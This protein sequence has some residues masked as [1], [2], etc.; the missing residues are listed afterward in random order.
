MRAGLSLG[1]GFTGCRAAVSLTM[2]LCDV[3]GFNVP[4]GTD[5]ER[6]EWIAHEFDVVTGTSESER[7]FDFWPVELG[8]EK[9]SLPENVLAASISHEWAS[10]VARDLST[11]KLVGEAI[12]VLP[13][14]LARA[15]EMGDPGSSQVPVA[16]V[17]WG[18]RRATLS[19]VLNRRA[20]FVRCLRD[21][22]FAPVISALCRELSLSHDEAQKLLVE[23]GLPSKSYGDGDELQEVIAEVAAQPLQVFAEELDRTLVFLRQQRRAIIP[24]KIVL[25][26]GG[27]AVRNIGPYLAEKLSLPVAPWSLEGTATRLDRN[28]PPLPI[29]GSAVA[30]SA[31][32]WEKA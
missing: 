25:F 8:S 1:V 7:E 3:R 6:R 10:Q 12:D 22:G 17:D 16:A 5:Q 26:G 23:R 21:S 27:A 2:S 32:A 29:L 13:M 31:L 24:Q 20:V 9:P 30:L 15:V 18:Y 14:A 11:A 28:Q 19:L 4:E